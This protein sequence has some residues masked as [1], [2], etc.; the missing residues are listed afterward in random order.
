M[1]PSVIEVT[2][3]TA[4]PL[5]PPNPS[6]PLPPFDGSAVA[7][8][9]DD[10]ELVALV[11]RTVN[12]PPPLDQLVHTR[13]EHVPREPRAGDRRAQRHELRAGSGTDLDRGWKELCARCHARC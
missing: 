13:R 5:P 10:P 2:A 6:S 1:L 4:P 12:H 11:N 7:V 8:V 3:A 9:P